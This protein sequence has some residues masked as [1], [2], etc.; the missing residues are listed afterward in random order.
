[1]GKGGE[2]ERVCVRE[3]DRE[4]SEKKKGRRRAEGRAY[5]TIT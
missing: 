2:R 5:F 4:K 1:M 3:K